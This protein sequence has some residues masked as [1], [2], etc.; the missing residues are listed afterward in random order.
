GMAPLHHVEQPAE[1][2]LDA[3]GRRVARQRRVPAIGPVHVHTDARRTTDVVRRS[4]DEQNVGGR[5]PEGVQGDAVRPGIRFVRARLFGGHDEVE[6][7][8]T[9]RGAVAERARAIRDDEAWDRAQALERVRRVGPRLELTPA[10][11][12]LVRAF[13]AKSDGRRALPTDV[14]AGPVV[15]APKH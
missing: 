2:W 12:E 14:L 6:R 11:D 10:A 9:P 5:E 1:V 7:S 13:T 4:R 8:G 3:H 15:W